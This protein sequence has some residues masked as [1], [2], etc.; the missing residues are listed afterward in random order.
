VVLVVVVEPV[1]TPG[2]GGPP[3]ATQSEPGDG[4]HRYERNILSRPDRPWSIRPRTRAT[5]AIRNFAVSV[6]RVHLFHGRIGVEDSSTKWEV[7]PG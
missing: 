7:T 4:K 3:Q 6:H 2:C 5:A 1:A